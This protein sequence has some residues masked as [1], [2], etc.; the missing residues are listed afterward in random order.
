MGW[1]LELERGESFQGF[2]ELFLLAERA[3]EVL[4]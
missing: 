1:A 3:Y 2:F 4:D